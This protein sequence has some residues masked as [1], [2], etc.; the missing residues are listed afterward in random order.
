MRVKVNM[1]VQKGVNEDQILPM[2]RYFREKG[3]ILRLIEF[4]DVGNS[5][6]WDLK[7]SGAQVRRCWR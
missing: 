2:A 5:N 1:V 6:N 7:R 3:P 4:M